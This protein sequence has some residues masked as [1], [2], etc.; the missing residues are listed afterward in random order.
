MSSVTIWTTLCPHDQP[1]SSTVGV[2]TWT[3]AVP[4]GR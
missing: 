3:L 2:N 4:T 1:F